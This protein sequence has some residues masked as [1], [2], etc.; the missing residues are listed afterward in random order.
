MGRRQNKS[1]LVVKK[2]NWIGL[3]KYRVV[4]VFI[5]INPATVLQVK[6]FGNMCPAAEGR[7]RIRVVPCSATCLTAVLCVGHRSFVRSDSL[8]VKYY[9]HHTFYGSS[10]PND[11][12]KHA[13]ST[14]NQARGTLARFL[15]HFMRIYTIGYAVRYTTHNRTVPSVA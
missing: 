2:I 14:E 4:K 9:L 12:H 13:C 6:H 7:L 3:H 5:S 11:G 8:L 15:L 1:T 10:S